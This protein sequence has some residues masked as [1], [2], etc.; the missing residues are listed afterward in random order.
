MNFRHLNYYS[1]RAVVS[2]GS[3]AISVKANDDLRDFFFSVFGL[4]F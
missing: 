2:S 4:I 3:N 1:E